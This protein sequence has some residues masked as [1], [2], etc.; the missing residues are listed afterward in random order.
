VVTVFVDSSALY[1]LFDADDVNHTRARRTLASL[2]QSHALVTH[3]YVCVETTTLLQR[4]V[5][6]DAVQ[7]FVDDVVPVLTVDWV[8]EPLHRAAT[9]ACLAAGQ[10][11]VSLVDW[12]SFVQMRRRGIA[13]AFA[14]DRHFAQQGFE[15]VG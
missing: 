14:Y 8:D 10:R 9:V 11:N 6:L 15:L 12:A 4:R 1:A 3:S 7:A 13:T 2:A 5:G